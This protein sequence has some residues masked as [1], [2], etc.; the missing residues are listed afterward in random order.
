MNHKISSRCVVYLVMF[1]EFLCTYLSAVSSTIVHLFR[2][3]TMWTII[4]NPA[5]ALVIIQRGYNGFCYSTGI[6]DLLMGL[7]SLTW[8]KLI[9]AWTNIFIPYFS[10]TMPST[11]C[12]SLLGLKLKN[13]SKKGPLWARWKVEHRPYM[14]LTKDT[15]AL[16]SHLCWSI[17]DL[18]VLNIGRVETEPRYITAY[19]M[20]SK[21]I[22]IQIHWI[23]FSLYSNI[24][25]SNCK[26]VDKVHHDISVE[27]FAL[28]KME[29]G[30]NYVWIC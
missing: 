7:I 6:T 19:D 15:H 1:Q 16:N 11:D 14:E 21:T 12:L 9:L 2:A 4:L 17:G 13:A 10:W 20:K 18:V 26:T 29:I 22:R 8:F 24:P 23:Y 28:K 3:R 25:T 5:G 30:M 27:M